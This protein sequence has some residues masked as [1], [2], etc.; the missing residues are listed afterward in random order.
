MPARAPADEIEQVVRRWASVRSEAERP[1]AR[2]PALRRGQMVGDRIGEARASH[3]KYSVANELGCSIGAPV[4]A[5][6]LVS[7]FG[8]SAS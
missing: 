2:S 7:D 6:L 5:L 1:R 4:T 8:R 3:T